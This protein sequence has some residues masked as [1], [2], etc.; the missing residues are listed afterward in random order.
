MSASADNLLLS[1]DNSENA[2][3]KN[4]QISEDIV[5]VDKPQRKEAID[6]DKTPIPDPPKRT[7]C[8]VCNK[9]L[10]I[11]EVSIGK[12]KCESLFC[13]KHRYPKEHKCTFDY[14]SLNERNLIRNN[15]PIRADKLTRI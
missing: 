8:S 9:K 4:T 6:S 5:I 14:K 7:G 10:S 11:V 2:I 15:P 1:K 12:C 13:S 3:K